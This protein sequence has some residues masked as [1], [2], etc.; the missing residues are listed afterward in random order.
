VPPARRS[1][2]FA[3]KGSVTDGGETLLHFAARD[4]RRG[5]AFR[6]SLEPLA[7]AASKLPEKPREESRREL[8]RG[9]MQVVAPGSG[10]AG[11]WMARRRRLGAQGTVRGIA[12]AI[13]VLG[14]AFAVV[15][16]RDGRE[17]GDLA[18]PSPPV[19]EAARDGGA[20]PADRPRVAAPSAE[21]RLAA[22]ALGAPADSPMQ[23][24]SVAVET[25]A[26]L[27]RIVDPAGVAVQFFGR[28]FLTRID[29]PAVPLEFETVVAGSQFALRDVEPGSFRLDLESPLHGWFD[30]G[31]VRIA[32]GESAEAVVVYDGPDESGR[33]LFAIEGPLVI[34]A[35]ENAFPLAPLVFHARDSAGRLVTSSPVSIPH[36]H[37]VFAPP[38]GFAWE[39]LAPGHYD[40]EID[41]PRFRPVVRSR[42]RT[43][44]WH[45]IE[46]EGTESITLRVIASDD[47]RAVANARVRH[48]LAEP[49]GAWRDVSP[50]GEVRIDA[51]ARGISVFHV[52]A[53]GYEDVLVTF[54]ADSTIS[55]PLVVE[56]TPFGTMDVVVTHGGSPLA[57][58]AV[59]L[60]R[61]EYHSRVRAT[62]DGEGRARFA[63]IS[64][65]AFSVSAFPHELIEA[66]TAIF[67][68]KPR[69]SRIWHVDVPLATLDLRGHGA[70]AG[71][72]ALPPSSKPGSWH[73]S[74]DV[75]APDFVTGTRSAKL[76]D[77]GVFAFD[78]LPGGRYRLSIFYRQH[79]ESPP[80]PPITLAD[81]SAEWTIVPASGGHFT[82][83]VH[84]EI[85]VV[86]GGVTRFERTI[87]PEQLGEE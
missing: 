62:T 53:E 82:T 79:V 75:I 13:A 66:R 19:S 73:A 29:R 46:L 64:P 77:G 86:V 26:C 57:G 70:V 3:G 59:V 54:A 5:E 65:G 50:Q 32:A 72:L 16:L 69:A 58:V 27:G 14:A 84:E 36:P 40:I 2:V 55:E 67:S 63:S 78:S 87:T 18:T 38:I 21:E 83:V 45:R 85:I 6:V 4:P 81:E 30:G 41:D 39:D 10:R 47:A 11:G 17:R 22:E 15:V 9:A 1:Q 20:N 28:A 42:A 49:E 71:R 68:M 34:H 74:L 37:N 24:E 25:G 44:R 23:R 61:S 33:L 56:L 43:G 76:D 52:Q 31:E 51:V 8:P 80:T 48:G 7:S 35:I 60:S 12:C